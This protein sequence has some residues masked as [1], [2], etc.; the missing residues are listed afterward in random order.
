MNN[1]EKN[2]YKKFPVIDGHLHM[3]RPDEV[4]IMAESVARTM[5][6]YQYDRVNLCALVQ[7]ADTIVDPYNNIRCFYVKSK[8]NTKENPNRV[9]VFGNIWHYYD[10]RDTAEGYLE[11]VKLLMAQGADGIKLLDGKPEHAKTLA[12]PLDDPIF[13]KMY[14]YLEEN[15]IPIVS[16][17]GDPERNCDITKIP[18]AI[19][20]RGW[21]YDETFPTLQQLRDQT[22]GILKKFPKL[23]LCL[24]HFYFW[25]HEMEKTKAFFERWENVCFDIT[26][27]GE[28]FVGFSEHP[29]EWRQ[30]FIDYADR[31]IC[32]TD[33]YNTWLENIEDYEDKL[34]G[35]VRI[36]QVRKMLEETEA[37]EDSFFG[38]LQPMH[39]PEE[40][41]EKIYYK[42]FL[43]FAGDPKPLNNELIA[44]KLDELMQ[45]EKA[46]EI[47]TLPEKYVGLYQANGK[48]MLYYFH[49]K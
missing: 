22:E 46:G 44:S 6:Y 48:K 42:N 8:L 37:F 34:V 11:Q 47:K 14:A 32:G 9:Y 19:L 12:R 21:Y 26:P 25:G 33:T 28:M 24:A 2:G 49:Q 40:A 3:L 38:R 23:K 13:D 41:L 31:I 20:K 43:A 18:E 35:A 29:A 17:V 30:F 27:G 36:N 16:H 4:D 45:A 1:V 10:E 5:E 39:L 7:E 15:Q